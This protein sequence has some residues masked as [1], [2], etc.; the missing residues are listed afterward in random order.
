MIVQPDNIYVIPPN[1]DMIIED[2]AL[3]L[4]KQAEAHGFSLPIDLFFRSLAKDKQDNA[5]GIILSGTGSDGTLGVRAIKAEYGMIMVQSPETSEY[6][7]MPHSA[8]APGL[9]DFILPPYRDAGPARC[10][11]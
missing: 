2:N 9:V 7:G 3:H 1:Y 5:V 11:Y 4:Q 6:D 10:V 8:I